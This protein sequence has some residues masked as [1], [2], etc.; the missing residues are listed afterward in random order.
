MNAVSI[1]ARCALSARFTSPTITDSALLARLPYATLAHVVRCCVDS[2]VS[3]IDFA[4]KD[5]P[6]RSTQCHSSSTG[7][8]GWRPFRLPAG[9]AI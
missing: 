4:I 7:R 6:G 5:H 1:R 8:P 3:V 9:S 2:V